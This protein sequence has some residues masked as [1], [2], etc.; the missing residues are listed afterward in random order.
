MNSHGAL[1]GWTHQDLGDNLIFSVESVSDSEAAKRHE[2]DI[3]Q[4]VMTKNQAATLAEYLMR[5]SG[6]SFTNQDER[7]W[8][9]RLFG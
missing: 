3:L 9:R 6:H 1:V 7:S 2:P 4:L 8:F 5:A